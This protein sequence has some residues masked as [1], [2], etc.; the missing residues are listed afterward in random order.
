[1]NLLRKVL[2][3]VCFAGLIFL[4]VLVVFE[5]RLVL[6]AGMQVLGRMHPLLLHFPIVLLVIVAIGFVIKTPEVLGEFWYWIRLI[7]ALSAIGTAIMGMLLLVEQTD[8]G[9]VLSWHKWWGVTTA[10]LAYVVFIFQDQLKAHKKY[11]YGISALICMSLFLTGHFGATI[12]HGEDYLL[13]PIR[14]KVAQGLVFE[15]VRVFPDIIQPILSNKCGNCHKATTMKG[16]LSLLDSISIMKGGKNGKSIVAG[17]SQKSLLYARLILPMNDKKHMPLAD[18]PQLSDAEIKLLDAWIIAGAPFQQLLVNRNEADSFSRL[19]RENVLPRLVKKTDRVFDFD[20]ADA[21][22]VAALNTNYRMIKPL[23]VAS[24]ALAV[25]FFGSANYSYKNLQELDPIKE[26]IVHLHLAKM[27]VTNEQLAW[28]GQLPNLI[29]LNLNY[30]DIADGQLKDLLKLKQVTSISVVGTKLGKE[31]ISQL[32]K[33]KPLKEL[34]VWNTALSIAEMKA[35]QTAAPKLKIVTGNLEMDT[36]VVVLNK[37]LIKTPAGFFK[38]KIEIELQHVIKGTQLFYTVDGKEPDSI[39]AKLYQ[40]PFQIDSTCKIIVKAYKK[41][42]KSSTTTMAQFLKAGLPISKTVLITKPD[43]KYALQADRILHDLD[44]GEGSDFGT[45]WLGYQKN[46]AIVVIDMG[47]KQLLR[48]L[49]ILNLLNLGAHIFPPMNM[50]V[51]GSNDQENWQ[52]LTSMRSMIPS[53]LGPN[54]T[55]ILQLKFKPTALRYLKFKAEHLN[56]LPVWHTDKG[57]PGWFFMSELVV[58]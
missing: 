51:W 40:G 5:D 37:P 39:H 56:K 46:D 41:G 25:S 24:P 42:W 3:A 36:M 26:Q 58:N 17:N 38:Q 43:E 31:G 54:S 1:M 27:P 14:T 29:H 35:V 48:E 30:T 9:N 12:T 32:V 13:Q 49:N 20:A 16:G 2:R 18:K 55:P 4:M 15:E 19:A 7:A 57:K 34:Y 6:P 8:D 10:I 50:T 28:I 23:G 52:L 11:A 21:K 22:T 44:A 33:I 45:R 53:K 47:V